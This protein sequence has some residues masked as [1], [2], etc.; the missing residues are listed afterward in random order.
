MAII[1]NLS[2]KTSP[3][4]WQ[5]SLIY[6]LFLLGFA[7]YAYS[8]TLEEAVREAL[9]TNPQIGAAIENLRASEQAVKITESRF[10]PQVSFTT[11]TGWQ[12]HDSGQ[13]ANP[14]S[15]GQRFSGSVSLQQNIYDGSQ[16]A[17][18]VQRGENQ[19]LSS[20]YTV[21]NTAETTALAAV[22]VYLQTMQERELTALA[23]DNLKR[24]NENLALVEKKV[25]AG[26]ATLSDVQ[27]ALF[28]VASAQNILAQAQ[29]RLRDSRATYKR[30]IGSTPATMIRP[31]V[32]RELLP[33]NLQA[34]IGAALQNSPTIAGARVDIETARKAI[35]ITESGHL[36]KVDFTLTGGGSKDFSTSNSNFQKD[37]SG[38]LGVSYKIYD[39][40]L[41]NSTVKQQT[42]QLGSSRQ[43]YNRAVR[44]VEESTRRAWAALI[45]SREAVAA[46]QKENKAYEQVREIFVKQYEAG[47]RTLLD[48]LQSES[49]LYESQVNL[50]TAIYNEMYSS[51]RVL[52]ATGQ[53]L[54]SLNIITPDEP[55]F[56]SQGSVVSEAKQK[57]LF[58]NSAVQPQPGAYGSVPYYKPQVANY[59]GVSPYQ[60]FP[61]YAP[62]QT[63]IQPPQATNSPISQPYQPASAAQGGAQ[64][65]GGAFTPAVPQFNPPKAANNAAPAPNS[66]KT[67]NDLFNDNGDFGEA[68]APAPKAA[69]KAAAAAPAP[70]AAVAPAPA[71]APAPAAI[72]PAPKIGGAPTLD[73]L[74]NLDNLD[75]IGD[76]NLKLNYR[77]DN[78]Q[79]PVAYSQPNAPQPLAKATNLQP[80]NIQQVATA[81]TSLPI[82]DA[83]GNQAPK[84]TN[85]AQ[86]QNSAKTNNVKPINQAQLNAQI[87]AL[88]QNGGLLPQGEAN[89]DLIAT[90]GLFPSVDNLQR[91]SNNPT[92]AI[93]STAG[94]AGATAFGLDAAS[95]ARD[96]NQRQALAYERAV[97]QQQLLNEATASNG[98]Y[99]IYAPA[100]SIFTNVKKQ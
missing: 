58:N 48:V 13:G 4:I 9:Q 56:Y 97:K 78:N 86:A 92:S 87:A 26:A 93:G 36:P 27:T 40:G 63:P 52:Q 53:L 39:G 85:Q 21:N 11:S 16:T 37:L 46:N 96:S 54:P 89:D 34:A 82:V 95:L 69:P 28:R 68:Q 1:S 84:A 3:A 12:F 31:A 88:K 25:A 71:P 80:L 62:E 59:G 90:K 33:R 20:R 7:P 43:N 83:K 44:E 32:P 77:F 24:H 91:L 29:S 47:T 57:A 50:I 75:F 74:E 100:P 42:F 64:G 15:T 22:Q 38:T 73:D 66:N 30:T 98:Q 14:R 17:H 65:G 41:L 61:N 60:G 70:K 8:F 94:L 18:E 55:T 49:Q 23:E 10:L 51:Y 72:K 67:M 45:A 2:F 99:P 19:A 5:K 6:S 35:D 79:K 81:Q 76:D